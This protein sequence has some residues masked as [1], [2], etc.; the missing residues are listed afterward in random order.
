MGVDEILA[1][2]FRQII[3]FREPLVGGGE[4]QAATKKSTSFFL[5][6][7]VGLIVLSGAVLSWY[8]VS[9]MR[10]RSASGE[11]NVKK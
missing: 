6:A 3:D 1:K 10:S 9:Q 8:G 2:R 11:K 4:A 5:W 7:G